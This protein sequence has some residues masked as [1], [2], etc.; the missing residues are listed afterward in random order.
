MPTTAELGGA[1]LEL[2]LLF[3]A[4]GVA[5]YR[6]Q[7]AA[8]RRIARMF[9]DPRGRAAFYAGASARARRHG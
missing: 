7:R 5:L 4:A 8:E 9:L 3:A 6:R 2:A 1:L